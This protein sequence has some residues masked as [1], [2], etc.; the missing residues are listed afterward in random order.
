MADKPIMDCTLEL[1][2]PED[3][4]IC[5]D[6]VVDLNGEI[7]GDYYSFFWSSD[8]GYY[9]E[10]D[11]NPS[12][13]VNDAPCTFTLT[14]FELTGENLIENGDFEIGNTAFESDY[15]IGTFSCYG[16]GFLDCEGTYG[17][18]TNPAIAHSAWSSCGDHTTG[19]GNMMVVN[20]APDF[21]NIWCQEIDVSSDTYYNFSAWATSVHPG[22]PGI[23]QFSIDGELIGSNFGLSSNTCLWEEFN[24]VW[25]SE[26]DGTVEICVTNQNTSTGG[27]DFAI[28]DISFYELCEEEATFLVEMSEFELDLDYD[29]YINCIN[30]EVGIT[31]EPQEPGDY[32]FL[33]STNDGLIEGDDEDDIVT[34]SQAGTY[35]VTVTNEFGCEQITSQYIGDETDE[36]ELEVFG[37]LILGCDDDGTEIIIGTNAFDPVFS[38]FDSQGEFIDDGDEVFLDQI[39][40]YTVYVIDEFN[41]CENQIEFEI[42]PDISIPSI[43]LS[44]SNPLGCLNDSSIIYINTEESTLDIIWTDPTGNVLP[45][46]DLDSVIINLPG[47]YYVE[48]T[49]NDGCENVNSIYIP[50]SNSDVQTELLAPTITCHQDSFILSYESSGEI[51]NI[52]WLYQNEPIGTGDSIYIQSGGT[53]SFIG[54]DSLGCEVNDSVIVIE[55]LTPPNT[56][57]DDLVLSC[58]DDIVFLTPSDIS[59][60]SS[61]VWQNEENGIITEE[62]TLWTGSPSSFMVTLEGINGCLQIL[63]AEII[64]SPDFPEVNLNFNHIDCIDTVAS[65]HLAI[66]SNEAWQTNWIANN[67][68]I[69][70]GDTL[71]VIDSGT[72]HYH[73]VTDSGCEI[74]DSVIIEAN[75]EVPALDIIGNQELNCSNMEVVLNL[76]NPELEN[77]VWS[78]QLGEI[79]G[80]DS[81][82]I[83]TAGTYYVEAT[84]AYGC[85]GVDSV[86]ITSNFNLAGI[87][88]SSDTLNCNTFETELIIDNPDNA[89]IC[90]DGVLVDPN[91]QPIFLTQ[92]TYEV[93]AKSQNGCSDTLYYEMP[94]DTIRPEVEIMIG[95]I[96]CLNPKAQLSASPNPDVL[97]FN[98]F[99]LNGQ[100]IAQG[101]NAEIEDVGT[102]ILIAVADNGCTTTYEFDVVEDTQIPELNFNNI[103]L[104]CTNDFA[105][106]SAMG[107]SDSYLYEWKKT[108]SIVSDS[109]SII[110]DVTGNYF[111]TV[112]D[113]INGCSFDTL[114]SIQDNRVLIDSV[115]MVLESEC[116]EDVAQL[117]IQNIFGGTPDY[118]I[119]VAEQQIPDMFSLVDPGDTQIRILDSEG[120]TLDTIITFE[121]IAPLV[122]DPFIDADVDWPEELIYTINTNRMDSEILNISWQPGG[123]FECSDCFEQIFIPEQSLQ[124]AADVTDIFGCR[125]TTSANIN[126]EKRI[127]IF[128][129]NII[130]LNNG[131]TND[132][133]FPIGSERQVEEVESMV[134]FDR[135]GSMVFEREGFQINDPTSGWNGSFNNQAIAQGVYTYFAKIRLINDEVLTFAGDVTVVR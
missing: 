28:D 121:N 130:R 59:D 10:S 68:N 25:Y 74:F 84:N 127:N 3:L 32:Q 87:T 134:I 86:E 75:T 124:I 5:G 17:V 90:I 30:E 35:I 16:A 109:S 123:Y 21:Q 46:E 26:S 11:L 92:G 23:L 82:L 131:G 9:N 76:D 132:R 61:I 116:G 12:V 106:Y 34:V 62:D 24:E 63:N 41:G 56:F 103:D 120:C 19:S 99:N 135:W 100:I 107:Q 133:F 39:G 91:T 48:V 29:G 15:V 89:D 79:L 13:F 119:I 45:G 128:F 6:E 101:T 36:V 102:Y 72:F 78:N 85:K 52:N 60:L 114:F 43:D 65:I 95:D 38:W 51:Q 96:T 53:Y 49:F 80:S 22:S 37:D 77:I 33:W 125:A 27:N 110:T 2:V 73:I 81:V 117:N 93:I 98:W 104:S 94:I 4:V 31:V 14:A 129:P 57:I 7:N 108:G 126:V 18:I 50:E 118:Q 66:F 20:G 1:T 97:S 88:L 115:A 58:A 70:F 54:I 105:F 40:I 55:D 112:I 113:S 8:H 111:L 47:T 69:S 44:F 122:L 71:E 64:A 42:E 83:K 67:T